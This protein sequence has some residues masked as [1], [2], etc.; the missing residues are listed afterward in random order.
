MKIE[1]LLISIL[2]TLT[3]VLSFSEVLAL[4]EA[5]H[6]E[7]NKEIA[8]NT[9][10]DFSFDAY[11]KNILGMTDGYKQK[12]IGVD[13]SGNSVQQDIADWLGYGGEQEDR[14]GDWY[15]YLPL[16]GQPTRS[17][18]HFHNPLK[19]W[20]EAGLND[21]ILGILSYTGQSQILWAQ[22]PNQNVGGNWSWQDA[23]GYF[24]TA[25]TSTNITQ[26]EEYFARTFRGVGQLM[27][28]VEDASVPEHT[29]NDAHV[30]PAYEKY[31]MNMQKSPLWTIWINNPA[32]FDKTILDIPSFS[33]APVRI[34]RIIDTDFYDSLYPDPGVTVNSRIGM[35]EYTNANFLSRDTMFTDDLNT[36]HRHYAPYPKGSNAILWT[37]Y[38]NNQRYLKKTGDGEPVNHLAIASILYN[39]RM[40]YFPQYHSL[41]PVGLDDK[42]YEEYAS[43]LIPRAVG[44][45]AG[46]L[47]YFF[48]GTLEI[49]PPDK[50][51]YAVADGRQT[52][53]VD[54]NGNR[55]QQFTKIRAKVRN[56]TPD[57]LPGEEVHDCDIQQSNC[58]LQ[59]VAKYKIIPD[60][61]PYLVNYPPDGNVMLNTPF[62]YSVS[63]PIAIDSLSSETPQEFA[64]DFSE[65]PIPAGITDLYLQVV[66]KGTLGNETDIAVAVGM[67]DIMEPTHQVFWNLTDMYSLYIQADNA[68]HLYLA[69]YNADY[70]EIPCI[71]Y[72]LDPDMCDEGL[73]D[74]V[75]LNHNDVPNEEDEPYVDPF[76]ITFSIGYLSGPPQQG[77]TVY[78]SA[79]IT[80][81][82]GEHIRLIALMDK[83]QDN[84]LVLEASDAVSGISYY[85]ITTPGVVNQ[86]VDGIWQTPTPLTTHRYGLDVDGITHIPIRQHFYTGVLGCYPVYTDPNGNRVCPYPEAES[87]PA[88][89]TPVTIPESGLMQQS[90]AYSQSPSFSKSQ[91]ASPSRASGVVI[92]K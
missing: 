21:S 20:N 18:N 13:A 59:A 10:N 68:Y 35:A 39:D 78:Y 57:T 82:N 91:S 74:L 34:S 85:Y 16:M 2:I 49:T 25:L 75:D 80:V 30:L 31:V 90:P 63:V 22:N 8:K 44:Y 62:S 84:Y 33:S 70:P 5:T 9:I 58:I 52:P 12:L 73:F 71:R 65:S 51:A 7:I 29:R 79:S 6:K 38:S 48:R 86:E 66:F 87:I 45:S 32:P 67:K 15:D 64:F 53:Y 17:V 11:L 69:D 89:L 27:H 81:H 1:K 42:C 60:Y 72:D 47:D 50:I 37:D 36:T 24:Y 23:R 4:K 76:P 92:V 43:K 26:R 56:S 46:L 61:D 19:G 41:L 40:K 3:I 14:P 83:P 54:G 55:H 88:E 28:L 77:Q